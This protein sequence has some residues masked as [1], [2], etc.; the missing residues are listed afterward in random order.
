[1]SKEDLH[2][3]DIIG[4][5]D[6]KRLGATLVSTIGHHCDVWRSSRLVIHK[7]M[8]EAL[9]VVVKCHRQPCRFAE[10]RILARDYGELKARLE[11][12]V[13]A[14]LFV[15]TTINDVDNVIAIAEAVQPW[16]NLANPTNE[17]EMIPLLRRLGWVRQQLQ[18]FVDAARDWY[19]TGK[20]I[21][22]YG[23]D[24]LVLDVNEQVKY[25][26]SFNVFFYTDL[27]YLCDEADAVLKERMDISLR[28]LEYLEYTLRESG[29]P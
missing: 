18:T 23:L 19:R 4:C 12:M 25:I 7:G 29:G 16:F 22:L 20:L 1:M 17:E 3:P 28:R 15:A 14:T 5:I 26:D 24:N 21:D 11:D 10:I 27:L 6:S 2:I 9:D 13:P 8:A